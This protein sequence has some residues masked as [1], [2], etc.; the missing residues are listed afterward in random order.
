[1]SI[2]TYRSYLTFIVGARNK[3][4]TKLDIG[5]SKK[6]YHKSIHGRKFTLKTI[7][8]H[9]CNFLME[10]YYPYTYNQRSAVLGN[11]TTK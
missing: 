4:T 1:M 6:K 8:T 3:T 10:K 2:K 5:V 9:Y 7:T 11:N